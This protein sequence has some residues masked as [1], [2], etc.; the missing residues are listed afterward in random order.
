MKRGIVAGIATVV[1]AAL[2]VI[3]I[4]HCSGDGGSSCSSWCRKLG[5]C[6]GQGD[7]D[8]YEEGGDW[9]IEDQRVCVFECGEREDEAEDAEGREIF[10]CVMGCRREID[11]QDFYDCWSECYWHGD[12][13]YE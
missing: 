10:N 3:T 11:C 7:N 5:E 1:L 2:V 12:E 6:E 9:T 13:Y 8:D 4:A